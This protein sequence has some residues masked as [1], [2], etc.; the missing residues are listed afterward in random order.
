MGKR[1]RS[2][3]VEHR[4]ARALDDLAEFDTYTSDLLPFLR[5]ALRKGLTKDEIESDPRVQAAL[6]ARQ[7]MMGLMDKDA[8]KAL[9][10]IKDLRDRQEGKAIE[11]K[12]VKHS[13]EAA[14]DEQLDARLKTLLA[15]DAGDEDTLE[16]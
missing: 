15:D 5:E 12:E 14:P 9:A 7:V 13:L 1:P 8:G 6:V 11:R 3:K 2:N 16:H 10:A 4:M